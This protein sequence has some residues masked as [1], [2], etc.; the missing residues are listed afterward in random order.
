[1]THA[2]EQRLGVTRAEAEKL[3]VYGPPDAASNGALA[4]QV[5]A[6]ID[7]QLSTLA[8][9]V[10]PH[11]AGQPIY[12]TGGGARLSGLAPR[13]A[14]VLGNGATCEPLAVEPGEGCSAAIV[15]L[16]QYCEREEESPLPLLDL[17]TTRSAE[18]Q[19]RPIPWKWA[20]LAG[21]LGLGLLSLRYTEALLLKP[22]LAQKLSAIKA[23]RDR[24]PHVER[25]LHFLQFL[26]TNQPAYLD[27][28]FVMAN[29]APAGARIDTVSMSRRG[30][31]SLRATLKDAPQ[32]AE[33]RSKLIDSSLFTSVTVEEQT[34]TPDR[35]K[36]VVRMVG[37]WTATG[38]RK[39]LAASTGMA[40][41]GRAGE[42]PPAQ[43]GPNPNERPPKES[44]IPSA[45]PQA[46]HDAGETGKVLVPSPV[47]EL[48]NAGDIRGAKR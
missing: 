24:L 22:R 35:Q 46:Q 30:D 33:F 41:P 18:G 29:A 10:L 23:Y 39:P 8:A 7:A 9:A 16:Q 6:A 3:K 15:G 40:P 47:N 4:Q 17:R 45:A 27:A 31:L 20:V 2:I 25:E 5:R 11:W 14:Q 13:L 19:A 43:G 32:V 36:V 48:P 44:S 34:P 37:Q 26:K 28:L 1:M 38:E 42:S 12:L 21:I